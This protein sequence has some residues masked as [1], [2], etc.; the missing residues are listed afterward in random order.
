MFPAGQLAAVRA[1]FALAGFE[2][3]LVTMSVDSDDERLFVVPHEDLLRMGDV[4]LLEQVL[5][6]LL[7]CKVWVL[8]SIDG[9]TVPFE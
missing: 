8:A 6:Q 3:E 5:T 7:G 1:A 2:G 9:P 4:R